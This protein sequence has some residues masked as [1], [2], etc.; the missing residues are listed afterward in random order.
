MAQEFIG[1]FRSKADFIKYFGESLQLYLPPEKMCN[2]DFFKQVLTDEKGLLPLAKVK[3]VTVPRYDELSVK[4]FWPMLQAD[5]T[6]MRYVPDPSGEGRLPDREYFWNIANTVQHDYVQRV[7]QHAAAQ[8]MQAQQHEDQHE[9]I[10]ISQE[11]YEKLSAMPFVSQTKG[12]TLHLLK[13]GSK[14]VPQERKRMKRE[15]LGTPADFAAQRALDQRQAH[16]EQEESKHPGP[17]S[18]HVPNIIGN[19]GE[20]EL[21]APL[22]QRAATLMPG[23]GA[24]RPVTEKSP[25]GDADMFQ[26]VN[27]RRTAAQE[28]RMQS[29]HKSKEKKKE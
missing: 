22:F 6:F 8:R 10:A 1:K 13:A 9:A 12:K 19:E 21:S 5:E 16:E 3:F 20:S 4:R 14:K 11:W 24:E 15:I 18:S 17:L 23:G 26:H 28:Y 29:R 7:I 25:S 27:P 2:K